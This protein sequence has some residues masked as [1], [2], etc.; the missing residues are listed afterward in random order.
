LGERELEEWRE[1]FTK[2]L[3]NAG[4]YRVDWKRDRLKAR[5]SCHVKSAADIERLIAELGGIVERRIVS[6]SLAIIEADLLPAAKTEPPPLSKE[7]AWKVFIEEARR[8]AAS[9]G[10]Q[11][12]EEEARRFF[13]EEWMVL[14]RTRAPRERL[15]ELLRDAAARFLGTKAV[16]V[17]PPA[18]PPVAPPRPVLTLAMM[19]P[20][21]RYL[22]LRYGIYMFAERAG[23][24]YGVTPE[25][26]GFVL[27]D[28]V[29]EITEVAERELREATRMRDWQAAYWLKE[30]AAAVAREGIYEAL[31]K[32]MWGYILAQL[33]DWCWERGVDPCPAD[34]EFVV[35]KEGGRRV[36]Y[37]GGRVWVE[38]VGAKMFRML[39]AQPP[40]DFAAAE[41]LYEKFSKRPSWVVEATEEELGGF[42]P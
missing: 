26:A 7:E 25:Y 10:L 37:S 8:L 41:A 9:A 5:I 28:I 34:V 20:E 29:A 14:E 42:Q 36:S 17:A 24:K 39:G 18:A 33:R 12:S 4:A 16:P 23:A 21:D 15:E 6:G 19:P 1:H 31:L 38:A 27:P 13:E 40:P 32:Y 22:L 2:L 35:V 11:F 3:K 30:E